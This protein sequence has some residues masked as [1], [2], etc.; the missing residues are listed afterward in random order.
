MTDFKALK[1]LIKGKTFKE[2]SSIILN[3]IDIDNPDNIKSGVYQIENFYIGKSNNIEI[4]I[5]NHILELLKAFGTKKISN[6]EKLYCIYKILLER[7]LK[8]SILSDEQEREEEFIKNYYP[9]LPL[10]NIEFVTEKMIELKYKKVY[11]QNKYW[12]K[13]EELFLNKFV[14]NTMEIKDYVVF[15]IE[16]LPKKRRKPSIKKP[17]SKEKIKLAKLESHSHSANKKK[18]LNLF[19]FIGVKSKNT[20]ELFNKTG[21]WRDFVNNKDFVVK[22]FNNRNLAEYWLRQKFLKPKTAKNIR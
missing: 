20:S 19:S 18:D 5:V 10:T 12:V 14:V 21:D 7:R 22:G 11:N 9:N 15:K 13:E 2:I 4:R 16:P 6:K 3:Y 8:I 17:K 1:E